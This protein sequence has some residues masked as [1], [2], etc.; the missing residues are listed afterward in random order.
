MPNT[1]APEFAEHSSGSLAVD[2]L[3]SLSEVWLSDIGHAF[4]R[5][6]QNLGGLAV[7]LS[8]LRGWLE[9]FYTICPSAAPFPTTISNFVLD[10]SDEADSRT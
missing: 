4:A 5:C 2:S 9:K 10:F 8:L 6:A 7:S 3:P 1:P